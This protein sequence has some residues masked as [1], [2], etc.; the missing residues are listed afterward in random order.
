MR[1]I[2][3]TA[4]SIIT[5]LNNI[6]ELIVKSSDRKNAQQVMNALTVYAK[7]KN[8]PVPEDKINNFAAVLIDARPYTLTMIIK[9]IAE[10]VLLSDAKGKKNKPLNPKN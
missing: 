5:L 1:H 3:D 8:F 4:K 7:G 9:D 6:D 2:S 10:S